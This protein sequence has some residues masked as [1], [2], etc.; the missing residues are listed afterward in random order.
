MKL[1]LFKL[2]IIAFI[3]LT[4]FT[5]SIS[6]LISNSILNYSF[7]F[8]GF[9]C[10]PLFAFIII[11]GYKHTRSINKYLLRILLLAILTAFPHRYVI[12][13]I[14]SAF[15]AQSFY[16]SAFTG[17]FC[18]M[19]IVIY[20]KI[21]N[22]YAK[23]FCIIFTVVVS[24]VIGYEF[25]PHA[26]IITYILFICRDKKFFEKAYYLVSY[27]LVITVVSFFMLKGAKGDNNIELY[28]NICLSGSI[29]AVPLLKKYDGTKGPSCKIFSYSYYLILLGIIVGA[30]ML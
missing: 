9:V 20:D 23:I 29:L 3:S 7:M 1:N 11:E 30:K 27:A 17:L 12:L 6:G 26:I 13:A 18:L 22:K 15:D 28:Q 16:S 4:F 21:A 19:C 14:A 5:L 8:L 25:A 24:F 10:V 2:K